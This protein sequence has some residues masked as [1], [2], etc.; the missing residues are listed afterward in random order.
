M[1]IAARTRI[2]RYEI[3]SQLGAGGMGE[4]YLAQDTKLDRKVAL[5]I[6]PPAVEDHDRVRRF[7]QEAKAASALN[8]PNILTIYEIDEIDSAQFIATEFIE[9]ET[10]RER[11]KVSPIK[12]REA[13]DVGIQVAS[14]LFATHSVGIVHRDVKPDNIM[15]R[16][17][18][19][20]K[21]LDF[22]LAKLVRDRTTFDP[23]PEA[24]T[25][26]LLN[27]QTGTLL[28]TAPYMSPEQARGI[29]VDARTDIWS[30]GCVLY[31]MV[32]ARQ[33]FMG[34]T[35][36]D[37]LS[38][39][40][41]REPES[42]THHLPEGPLEFD[43]IVCRA[44]R[45][46]REERYQTIKDLLNDL[47]NLKSELQLHS[48]KVSSTKTSLK[49]VS[50]ESSA[51]SVPEKSI[52]VLYFENMN[53]EKDSDYFCA[54]ITEDIITDL[55][56]IN[57]LKVVPRTDVLP[58][59]NKEVNTR[60]VGEALRVNYILEGSVRTAGN[61]IRI[62]AQ[63]INVRDGYHLWA[64]RFD[65]Q[66]ED[67]FDL[68]DEVSQK[69][70]AALKISLT[71][72]ERQVLAK[73]PTDD[74]RAYDFYMRGRELL[75]LKGKKNT[76]TAIQ[77]FENAVAIDSGFASSYAGLAEAYSHM[78]E[79]YDGNP[80]WLGEAIEMNQR[81]LTLD[82][83]SLEAQ[84]GIAMVYFHHRR[85]AEAKRTIE[86][87]LKKNSQFHPG[88]LR[89]GMIAELSDDLDSALEYYRRATELKPYDEDSW[90]SL[91]GIHRKLANLEA[92]E[93]AELKVIE[94][95]SRKLEASLDDIIV[96]SK[97]AEAYARFGGKEE[98]HATLRRVFELGP[99]DGLALYNC[100]CA[101]ALLGEKQAALISLRRAFESGFKTVAH[102]AKTDSAF[103]SMQSNVEFQQLVT[104]LQ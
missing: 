84:F 60:Q 78:Y 102:W 92:A 103:D 77:M 4:V 95:T 36:M 28:G 61:K 85:F 15:L 20:V 41:S 14:A 17:D 63:L 57:N 88:Y 9:G 22:G 19:I 64:E 67:I 49:T 56:K 30:L 10:L 81:A 58:F 18:G 45:K 71:D 3:Y 13:I 12:P 31:E 53:S 54:G 86:D 51:S 100:S 40:L 93:Q 59:R 62:T 21:V 55:S 72:L 43:R 76:E 96:M 97:L 37:V 91:A 27:T 11:I 73:K 74:L 1:S 87:I 52:A 29:E 32:A 34:A 48:L 16:R 75:Y 65:R 94:V 35:T 83:T 68:Q 69:I 104:E 98:A 7:I 70:A 39:I 82:P 47:N 5:K 2:G 66:V 33:P 89:L 24:Q 42:L 25:Q 79:W 6:L 99:N 101:Y 44:L 46:D 90:R 50:A 23:S 8:H 26:A 80:H 38:G